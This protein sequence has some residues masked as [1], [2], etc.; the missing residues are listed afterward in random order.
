[1][2]VCT[3]ECRCPLWA[4]SVRYLV[5][6]LAGGCVSLNTCA[7]NQTHELRAANALNY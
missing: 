4:S 3:L 5:G 2:W 6:G 7:G 1:M